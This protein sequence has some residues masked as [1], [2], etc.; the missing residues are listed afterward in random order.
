MGRPQHR[1]DDLRRR[2]SPEQRERL[3]A[4][5]SPAERDV[6]IEEVRHAHL[7]KALDE[8]VIA[9]RLSPVVAAGILDRLARGEDPHAL[10][11]EL[12]AAGVLILR[13]AN[14]KHDE[15]DGSA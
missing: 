2:L 5:A 6:V 15:G 14:K 11:R 12:R 10:R 13:S 7:D 1:R 8:A 4:A 9:G 3:A